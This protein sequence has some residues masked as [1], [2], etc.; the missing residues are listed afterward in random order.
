MLNIPDAIKTLYQ[1]DAIRKNF[2]VVFPNGEL[3][4]ITNS[5]IVADSVKFTES[6][7]SQEILKF[8]LAEASMVEFET[9]GIVN[10][11]G[12]KIQCFEEIDTSSLDAATIAAI[13]NLQEQ[14]GEIILE[15]ASDIGFGFYRISLG[16]FWVESCPRS[17][18]AMQNRRVTAYGN[19]EYNLLTDYAKQKLYAYTNTNS[20][21][22]KSEIIYLGKFLIEN[23][24]ITSLAEAERKQP[25]EIELSA[26]NLWTPVFEVYRAPTD[27]ATKTEWVQTK[28]EE[29]IIANI[30]N[31]LLLQNYPENL[32]E[33]FS[34]EIYESW[35]KYPI[36][37]KSSANRYKVYDNSPSF[38]PNLGFIKKFIIYDYR[39]PGQNPLVYTPNCYEVQY[40]EYT[41]R[42]NPRLQ[43]SF[44]L[45]E[46]EDGYKRI[47]YEPSKMLADISE[48]F[49][50]IYKQGRTG[51]SVIRLSKNIP[52]SIAAQYV[53]ELWWDEYDVSP[54]GSIKYK[55][56]GDEIEDRIYIFGQGESVYDMTENAFFNY[57]FKVSE[58]VIINILNQCF[59]PHITE[60][61]FTPTQADIKGLPYLEPGDFLVIDSGDQIIADGYY[62][63]EEEQ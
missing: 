28:T 23:F 45:A 63:T 24:G 50:G 54:I 15:A 34:N 10:M 5:N 11:Y 25:E 38:T 3:P 59:I 22:T 19:L 9:V 14:D 6:L 31:E 51:P 39:T 43:V 12:Y 1:Q 46:T 17:K 16:T 61:D 4:D 47:D 26:G 57:I 27:R 56:K 62:V 36:S 44:P 2:R 49:G 13:Q 55:I 18:G 29:R 20:N 60:V 30:K 41:P 52:V 33:R 35:F 58:T 8:G 48:I 40:T 7:C 21:N 53:Q 32:A 37:I 42:E